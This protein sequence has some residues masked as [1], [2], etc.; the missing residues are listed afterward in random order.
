MKWKRKWTRNPKKRENNFLDMAWLAF[1]TYTSS[2]QKLILRKVIWFELVKKKIIYFFPSFA[3]TRM[4]VWIEKWN[5]QHSSER[6][7]DKSTFS[8]RLVICL[9]ESFLD[10]FLYYFALNN[11]LLNIAKNLEII[12]KEFTTK[13]KLENNVNKLWESK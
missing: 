4:I 9:R 6:F 1:Y 7:H 2:E 3:F 5:E 12:E 13:K 10:N 11:F 8:S